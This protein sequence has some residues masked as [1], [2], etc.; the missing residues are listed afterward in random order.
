MH[1]PKNYLR[2]TLSNGIKRIVP[3]QKIVEHISKRNGINECDIFDMVVADNS[4]LIEHC[5][6]MKWNDAFP[7]R[8][9]GGVILDWDK[10]WIESEKE[11]I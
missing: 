2:I 3:V 11:L 5:R 6:F 4:I 1:W 10:E 8:C 7:C 9:M